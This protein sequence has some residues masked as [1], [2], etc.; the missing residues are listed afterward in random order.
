M[1]R[2]TDDINRRFWEAQARGENRA[3]ESLAADPQGVRREYVDEPAGL[4]LRPPDALAGRAILAIHGGGFVSGSIETHSRML[5]HLA[6]GAGVEVLAVEYPL[7]S[8]GHVFPSQIDAVEAAYRRLLDGG[9]TRVAVAG[10]SCGGT[11]ALALSVRA[12]DGGLA[13]PASLLLMS[14]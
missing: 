11:L 7:V 9:L 14:T 4:W 1:V 8:D 2:A 10:D 13:L 12:R 5:G 3:W 6:L